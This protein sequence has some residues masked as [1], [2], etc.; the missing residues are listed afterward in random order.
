VAFSPSDRIV[1]ERALATGALT[2][3]FADGRTVTYR[4]LVEL[5]RLLSLIDGSLAAAAGTP[6][7]ALVRVG[8]AS[9]VR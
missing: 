2:V 6:A 9:G 3:R 4:S 8:H 7:S 1:V 5:E